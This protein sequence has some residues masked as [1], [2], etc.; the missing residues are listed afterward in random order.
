MKKRLPIMLSLIIALAILSGCS[1]VESLAVR[2]QPFDIDKIN[3][4][5]VGSNTEFA[6]NIFRQLNAEDEIKS[7]FI[8]PFSISSALTMTY[9]GARTETKEAMAEALGYTQIDDAN[10]NESYKNL[11]RHL[12][13]IDK[14]ITLNISNS[15]W[16]R[17]G[18]SIED[19]FLTTNREVFDA[20]VTQLD[21]SRDD[22][23]D[24]I[25]QWI[26]DATNKKIE[27]MVGPPISPNVVMYLINAI[28]FKG[29]WTNQF[30]K[31]NT[32]S[33][34][35]Y[36]GNGITQEAMMMSMNGKV[37]FGQGDGFKAVRLPYGNGKKAMYIILPDED[38]NINDFIAELDKEYWNTI[39]DS[40]S[41]QESVQLRIPRFKLEYGIKNLNDSLKALGMGN[42]FSAT[43]DFSGIRNGIFIS[44]VLHKAV[45]EVNEEGSEAAAATVVVM[46]ESAANEPLTFIA[47]RPF[48]F[49]IAD[50]VTGTI[51]F[52]GKL[53]DMAQE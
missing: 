24:Q 51:L 17:E 48:V 45:I 42:A 10:L 23:A 29:D 14:E 5:T 39:K 18:E 52:M 15:I 30:N 3:V 36:A 47:D 16:I 7:V 22:A 46:Q 50:D 44:E 26:S 41:E 37:E 20:F 4:E 8:S 27:K 25:N 12:R 35:F 32:I 11:L 38:K 34:P 1:A 33:S 2:V 6:F 9:Q 19:E 28:Y 21:F 43:A 53:F 31:N 40:L 49:I 13:Q